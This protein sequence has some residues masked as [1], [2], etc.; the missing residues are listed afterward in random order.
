MYSKVQNAVDSLEKWSCINKLQLKMQM[1]NANNSQS[2]LNPPGRTLTQ[3]LLVK[4]LG[5]GT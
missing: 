5:T 1:K 3:S 2:I 4:V